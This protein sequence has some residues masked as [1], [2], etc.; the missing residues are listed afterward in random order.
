[1]ASR[2]S[3]DG[4]GGDALASFAPV[5]KQGILPKPVISSMACQ[6]TVGRR[7]SVPNLG[8]TGKQVDYINRVQGSGNMPDRCSNITPVSSPM[9]RQTLLA[10]GP[11]ALFGVCKPGSNREC[12]DSR[13]KA[14]SAPELGDRRTRSSSA[15]TLHE[16]DRLAACRKEL[17]SAMDANQALQKRLGEEA[18]KSRDARSEHSA[19]M[20][21]LKGRHQMELTALRQE[22]ASTMQSYT[23]L[24]RASQAA[25]LA[26]TAEGAQPGVS[27][28]AAAGCARPSGSS[29]TAAAPTAGKSDGLLG[30]LQMLRC[31]GRF[32]ASQTSHATGLALHDE[33]HG[34]AG[35]HCQDI[36]WRV[37]SE[38]PGVI[39][40]ICDY[41]SLSIVDASKEACEILLG[42]NRSFIG[43]QSLMSLF[44]Q[45]AS[46]AWLKRAITT[47]QDLAQT[48]GGPESIHGF[49]LHALGQFTLRNTNCDAFA[50]MVT[51][52]HLPAEGIGKEPKILVLL[53]PSAEQQKITGLG[54]APPT[55]AQQRTG[56]PPDRSDGP[57]GMARYQQGSAAADRATLKKRHL[58]TT[59]LAWNEARLGE[60][61]GDNGSPLWWVNSQLAAC[62]MRWDSPPG[63][64]ERAHI[65][66]GMSDCGSRESFVNM[67]TNH[68]GGPG[69]GSTRDSSL[70]SDEENEDKSWDAKR[71]EQLQSVDAAASTF[72]LD[73][74]SDF[75][76]PLKGLGVAEDG[77]IAPSDSISQVAA[78]RV[79][80]E[81]SGSV[82]EQRAAQLRKALKNHDTHAL[83][84]LLVQNKVKKDAVARMGGE[85]ARNQLGSFNYSQ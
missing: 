63:D 5:H 66:A 42:G 15:S 9:S 40:M 30:L 19:A 34:R 56:S 64:E 58:T 51:I 26:Q 20:V 65:P 79:V 80:S 54:K 59:S 38:V 68:V 37:L 41:P 33:G 67:H 21:H 36:C 60:Q 47:H 23:E 78:A 35:A 52:A 13:L 25:K 76:R 85:T 45:K 53:S 39:A 27:S 69:A 50:C 55:R 28:S 7:Q 11:P 77:D 12:G 32:S 84:M 75:R 2:L 72:K 74:D 24:R 16:D 31:P 3:G 71:I 22:L 43:T 10:G 14:R 57:D 8:M 44:S 4:I 82:R 48:C 29:C 81:N 83:N 18:L 17:Y 46:A 61:M 73:R 70:F 6:Q 62:S 49:A 1:M